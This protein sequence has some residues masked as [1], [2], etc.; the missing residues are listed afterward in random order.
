MFE[1]P[2]HIELVISD[3]VHGKKRFELALNLD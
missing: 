1:K 2:I 3:T